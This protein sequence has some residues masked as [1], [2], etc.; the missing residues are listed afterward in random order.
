MR[1]CQEQTN[2]D[3][4]APPK[5]WMERFVALVFWIGGLK[6]LLISLFFTGFGLYELSK[7]ELSIRQWKQTQGT[8]LE[9]ETVWL[10]QKKGSFSPPLT[11]KV[12]YQY[13]VEGC[14]YE[15]TR[16]TTGEPILFYDVQQAAQFRKQHPPGATVAVYYATYAPSQAALIVDRSSG[17]WILLGFGV[18]C[19]LLVIYVRRCRRQSGSPDIDVPDANIPFID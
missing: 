5:S 7:Q 8:V 9:S 6:E 2:F 10:E 4:P 1:P 3:K 13:V 15:S 16:I 17:P 12:R 19:L 18:P 11:V 14:P